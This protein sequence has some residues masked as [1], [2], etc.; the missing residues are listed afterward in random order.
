MVPG[1]KSV[2]ISKKITNIT[3][4]KRLRKSVADLKPPNFGIIVRTVAEGKDG[5][6]FRADMNLLRD[7][8]LN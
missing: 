6:S 4:K 2:G 3:E 7:R 5:R 8:P 1:S